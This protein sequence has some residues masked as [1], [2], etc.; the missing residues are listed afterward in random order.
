MPHSIETIASTRKKTK[1]SI[2]VDSLVPSDLRKPAEALIDL[3]EDYYTH[4]N[5]I[6]QPSAEINS[7]VQARDIDVT[8]AAYLDLIQKEIASVIPK[9]TVANR[10][11]LYKNLARY[12]NVRGSKESIELFFKIIF[13][14]N[15]E[16]YFPRKDMLIAS[17]GVWLGNVQRPV[18][19]AAPLLGVIGNGTGAKATVTT[20]NGAIRR[21]NVSNGGTLYPCPT[22]SITGDGTNAVL[23]LY[24]AGGVVRS[25]KVLNGGSGYTTASVVIT[26]TNTT[27]ATATAEIVNGVISSVTV[28]SGGTGYASPTVTIT[29]N[30]T[31]ATALA[32]CSGGVIQHVQMLTYGSGYSTA[33]IAFGGATGSGAVAAATIVNGAITQVNPTSY[34]SGYTIAKVALNGVILDDSAPGST[35]AQIVPN[36]E[37]SG[38][39][40][41]EIQSYRIAD[42]GQG[43]TIAGNFLG[44]STGTYNESRGFLSDNIK[45]QDSYFYQK[46]SY[47]IR[48]GNNFDVWS[49][50]FNKLVHPA[51][52][53]FFGEILILL[54]LLDGKSIMPLLQPGLISAE[55]LARIIILQAANNLTMGLEASYY[56][57][58]LNVPTGT[59]TSFMLKFFDNNS[60]DVYQS[61]TI[62]QAET[63]YPY[64]D[65]TISTVINTA[66]T[67]NGTTLGVN[68][69]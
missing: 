43:Y 65:Y 31:G 14:D 12:Y 64:D 35:Y 26:G 40:A 57:M 67:W 59:N 63:L 42:C 52:M 66:P 54:Q 49:D 61:M 4:I 1:E 30:G 24:V 25:I 34:G 37:R 32:Y 18:Y 27:L 53:I 45:L 19:S 10:V 7:M 9:N 56:K 3:L 5:E 33:S 11:N 22:A 29:G 62:E 41:G 15:A 36:I 44:Y 39:D 47:V 60:M 38:V 55:D 13:Q 68:Y 50:T 46:F 28:T 21:I 51:G 48:T 69:V 23:G 6:G 20:S 2:R 16:V 58:A 8:K 17:D